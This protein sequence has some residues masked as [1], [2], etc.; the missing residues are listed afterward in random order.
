MDKGKVN[1]KKSPL[2]RQGAQSSRARL[3]VTSSRH[4]EVSA[5]VRDVVAAEHVQIT[6]SSRSDPLLRGA[7]LFMPESWRHSGGL[8]SAKWPYSH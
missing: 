3:Q 7:W 1:K 8:A 4:A 6:S 2:C 5:S